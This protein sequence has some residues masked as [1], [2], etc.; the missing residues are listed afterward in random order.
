MH[1]LRTIITLNGFCV[2]LLAIIFFSS[3]HDFKKI[4]LDQKLFILIVC[5]TI[6][7]LILETMSFVFD[8]RQNYAAYVFNRIFNC[9]LYALNPI[10]SFLWSLYVDYKIF[11]NKKRLKKKSIYFIIP[12]LLI[13][14]ASFATLFCNLMFKLDPADNVYARKTIPYILA[15]LVSVF[16]IIAA[17]VEVIVQRHKLKR[18]S[19]FNLFFFAA[20]PLVGAILQSFFYGLS[21][22]WAS[23]TL[24]VIIL[25][26]YV[27][28]EESSVDYLTKLYNRK[29]LEDYLAGICSDSDGKPLIAGI[30]LDL[31]GLK[32]IN[33]NFGHNMGD[34]AL[35][36]TAEIIAS[37]A[38]LH[39]AARY[40]GDEFVIILKVKSVDEVTEVLSDIKRK[41]NDFNKEKTVPFILNLSYGFTIHDYFSKQTPDDFLKKMDEKM[42]ECKKLKQLYPREDFSKSA[43]R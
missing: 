20:P 15:T 24:S 8:L 27:Q 22:I 1:D 41:L 6:C 32:F 43:A 23:V 7:Q 37:S 28:S 21:L 31:D 35:E 2:I 4:M 30:M 42:Y 5:F 40:A 14:V 39:F 25:Y 11:S 36:K 29:R 26:I 19:F 17:A 34:F 38:G 10:T 18:K 33:D 16:Y 12:V 9:L 13:V 3:K